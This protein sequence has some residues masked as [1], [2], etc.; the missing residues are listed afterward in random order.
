MFSLELFLQV[1]H[2]TLPMK[3]PVLW[4]TSGAGRVSPATWRNPSEDPSSDYRP[5]E[6]KNSKGSLCLFFYDIHRESQ[7][8]RL[9]RVW[10]RFYT[11]PLGLIMPLL[12]NR[13]TH[14]QY[15]Y[16]SLAN[17]KPAYPRAL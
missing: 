11:F 17:V 1:E 5:G 12:Q 8:D 16:R 15:T 13:A 3:H 14:V 10:S 9:M 2:S 6:G 4:V 7:C